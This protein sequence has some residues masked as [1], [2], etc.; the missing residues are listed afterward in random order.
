METEDRNFTQIIS[1][2]NLSGIHS[3]KVKS[4]SYLTDKTDDQ[5]TDKLSIKYQTDN[6][7]RIIRFRLYGRL[8][9]A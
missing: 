7:R 1:Q 6:I 3:F 9:A 8:H 4:V 2:H 5:V